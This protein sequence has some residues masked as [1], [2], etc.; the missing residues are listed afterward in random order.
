MAKRNRKRTVQYGW[1]RRAYDR[2][3]PQEL[4]DG[5]GSRL[6]TRAACTSYSSAYGFLARIQALSCNWDNA[7]ERIVKLLITYD[8]MFDAYL[9]AIR[10]CGTWDNAN[11]LARILPSIEELDDDQ[12]AALAPFPITD[13]RHVEQIK[14]RNA[15]RCLSG[16]AKICVIGTKL[17]GALDSPSDL[18]GL[19]AAAFDKHR[20]DDF[21][22]A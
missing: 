14:L 11:L 10:V 12:I 3:F 20:P 17:P 4:L 19:T 15:G 21:R 18:L 1:P 9:Q 13:R 8:S 7:A 6:C 16:R 2:G 5:S 22:L